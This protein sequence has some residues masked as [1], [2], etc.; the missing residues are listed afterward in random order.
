MDGGAADDVVFLALAFVIASAL[1]VTLLLRGRTASP[2]RG[3][4]VEDGGTPAAAPGDQQRLPPP[5]HLRS[6]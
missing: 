6:R 5:E 4:T 1:T 2:D 3:P